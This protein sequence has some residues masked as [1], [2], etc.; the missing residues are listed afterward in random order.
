[1]NNLIKKEGK[2]TL[3]C[4]GHKYAIRGPNLQLLLILINAK[5]IINFFI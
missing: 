2:L 5:F 1:M 3:H 4:K